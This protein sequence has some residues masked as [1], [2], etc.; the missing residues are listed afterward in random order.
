MTNTLLAHSP[1]A[2]NLVHYAAKMQKAC[3]TAHILMYHCIAVSPSVCEENVRLMFTVLERSTLPVVRANSIIALGDLTV[4]FPNILEPWTQNLYARLVKRCCWAAA[5]LL[6]LIGSH[7]AGAE[8][9][10]SSQL[11]PS[12]F[13]LSQGTTQPSGCVVNEVFPPCLYTLSRHHLIILL[14]PPLTPPPATA[15]CFRVL[16]LRAIQALTLS[17][18]STEPHDGKSL[19]FPS[20]LF[21]GLQGKWRRKWQVKFKKELLFLNYF[22]GPSLNT[23]HGD[24]IWWFCLQ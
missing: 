1:E 19:L 3:I 9:H 13:I 15:W 20:T 4:R 17:R 10:A 23:C 11:M 5:T 8:A 22:F 12:S 21:F 14:N 2:C 16:Y 18:C 24:V 7:Q 6:S